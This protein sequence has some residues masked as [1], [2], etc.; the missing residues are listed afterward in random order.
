MAAP[1]VSIILPVYNAADYVAGA[2]ISV[3]RQSFTSFELIIINDGSTDRS[4]EIIRGFRD[5]R[6]R[7]IN[8]E[9][10]LGLQRSLNIGLAAS[11]SEYV[12][13]IDAD[14]EWIVADKLQEQ[15]NFLDKNHRSVVV[16]TGALIVNEH[17]EEITKIILPRTD[18]AI[19][20][21]IL[22]ANQFLHSS[23]LIRRSALKKV[24]FYREGAAIKHIEDYDLWLRL[25][26]VGDFYNL[27]VMAISYRDLSSS[28]SRQNVT[29]QLQQNIALIKVYRRNYPNYYSA[30][31]RNY[32]KLLVYGYVHLLSLRRFVYHLK[33]INRTERPLPQI[34]IWESLSHIA[35]GQNVLLNLLPSLKENFVITVIVPG[36]GQLSQALNVMGVAV[37]FVNPGNYSTGKK[38]LWEIFKY[39]LLFPSNFIK[40]SRLIARHDLIYVNS[41]RVMPA[42]IIGGLI[43][44]KPVIWHNHSLINDSSTRKLL[45]VLTK[46]SS[47]K[48]MIAVSQAVAD[49]YPELIKNTEI[50]YNGIDLNKFKPAEGLR[51]ANSKRLAVIGDLMPTKG[52]NILIESLAD[53]KDFNYS[54]KIIGAARVGTEYY[55]I[56]LK[57]ATTAL[58]LQDKI[59]FL[60][61]RDDVFKILP[62]SDLLILPA[63][64]PEA[65]PLVVLEALACGVPA[66]VSDLGGTREIIKEAD[67]GYLFRAGD[68]QD[69]KK[70][71]KLFFALDHDQ[72]SEMKRNC[73]GEAELK[74]NLENSAHKVIAVINN[75]LN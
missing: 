62:T 22:Q 40:S 71:I 7:I 32:L 8:N 49:Q 2:I 36:P 19:R 37:K 41:T 67:N 25:G 52:Q 57:K 48:K 72:V 66:I 35:G 11:E 70:K 60:G 27:P 46:F 43:F 39:L 54:L 18:Q 63:T 56:S 45:G 20:G 6:L 73:R 47:F 12:A 16:G 61:R 31:A 75:I 65:C 29:R 23:V 30:V 64:V 5:N 15:V 50:I 42:G 10:N 34:L 51:R 17:G 28:I 53:L 14:D 59:E 9:V 3:L 26:R 24:G 1:R 33:K 58:L 44:H 55:E 21:K 4:L 74:Y 68:T 38:S 69:L 13:R